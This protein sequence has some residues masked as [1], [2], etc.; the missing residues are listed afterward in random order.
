MWYQALSDSKWQSQR[1]ATALG[2]GQ[3]ALLGNVTQLVAKLTLQISL[4]L[5]VMEAYATM[6]HASTVLWLVC[7]VRLWSKLNR[8]TCQPGR[9]AQASKQVG[10]RSVG[11]FGA[12]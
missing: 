4:D 11:Q 1:L 5:R 6:Q 2:H 7:V 8:C 10:R 12:K 3:R 9:L